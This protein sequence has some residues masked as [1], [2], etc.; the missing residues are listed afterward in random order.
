MAK[1]KPGFVVIDNLAMA[2]AAIERLAATADGA[3]L[4]GL[5]KACR[6]IS[7]MVAASPDPRVQWALET[8]KEEKV[9]AQ[10]DKIAA[11]RALRSRASGLGVLEAGIIV[12]KVVE[13]YAVGD[14][15]EM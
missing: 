12:N 1:T 14:N 13:S 5:Q 10:S 7:E 4:P 6:K 15:S 9:N 11:V 2:L 8:L 3:D